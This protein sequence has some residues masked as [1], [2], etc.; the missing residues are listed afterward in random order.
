MAVD[1]PSS[2]GLTSNDD[3]IR[4]TD[5]LMGDRARGKSVNIDQ[6]N[7]RPVSYDSPSIHPRR[8]TAPPPL[9]D[10]EEGQQV[11]MQSV[12][13]IALDVNHAIASTHDDDEAAAISSFSPSPQQSVTSIHSASVDA[14]SGPTNSSTSPTSLY[15]RQSERPIKLDGGGRHWRNHLEAA[16]REAELL[17][18]M[19]SMDINGHV[20]LESDAANIPYQTEFPIMDR[21]HSDANARKELL[22]SWPGYGPEYSRQLDSHSSMSP[23]YPIEL[24]PQF[25]DQR[26]SDSKPSTYDYFDPQNKSFFNVPMDAQIFTPSNTQYSAD[27]QTQPMMLHTPVGVDP[28][29]EP[30]PVNVDVQRSQYGTKQLLYTSSHTNQVVPSD[31]GS[32]RYFVQST[33][34]KYGSST[35]SSN[36]TTLLDEVRNTKSYQLTLADIGGHVVEFSS[37]QHGSRFLQHKLESASENDIKPVF[38]ELLPNALNLSTDVFGNYVV[39]KLF[40]FGNEQRRTLLGDQLVGHV[41]SLSLQMYG[42][43]V[44]QKVWIRYIHLV[45][46][47]MS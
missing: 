43:R 33:P 36:S 25:T 8:T 47:L 35:Y 17:A 16:T 4:P 14:T 39:Q 26:A 12:L 1:G 2:R 30:F 15:L 9:D 18:S 45:S 22:E 19:R 29:Q 13:D 27:S 5:K 44:V 7:S 28:L 20:Q 3:F 10:D 32:S 6:R 11:R 37:D 42:C 23:S 31:Y 34:Q 46:A 24:A 38:N 41:L 21:R 40:E